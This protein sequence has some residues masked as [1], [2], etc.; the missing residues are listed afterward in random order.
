[1]R[2]DKMKPNHIHDH[3]DQAVAAHT[4]C[5]ST[6]PIF[7]HLEE[8]QLEEIMETTKSASYRKGEII[9]HAGEPS[10]SLYIVNN[11]KIR[12]Y[13]ISESGKEQ[14]VRI[15]HPGDF[16]GE[17]ALFQETL[18][19]SFAE[20]MEE[21]QVCLIKRSDLQE[22]LLKYPTISIKL[23]SEFS[24]KLE[25]TE[26]QTARFAT[27]KAETR[28]ALFLADCLENTHLDE[29]TLPMSKKDVASYLGITPETVSRKL[30]HL[31]EEGY[32]I[33][34]NKG[35]IKIVDLDGLLLV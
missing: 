12:I 19:E 2:G 26:K 14:L 1:M 5:V 29:F 20:A 6:V 22:L 28:V 11:G 4:A 13:R 27:E 23:L 8:K 16:T 7:N 18:H 21:T 35:R 34:K 9:Y 15:L 32:I 30:T 25:E 3:K 33:Q 17:Y 31:E 10:D 24:S